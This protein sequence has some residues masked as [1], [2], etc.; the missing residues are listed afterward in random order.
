[1]SGSAPRPGKAGRPGKAARPGQP[2]PAGQPGRYL[3]P[4]HPP[5]THVPIAAYILAAGFDVISVAGGASRPW[6]GQ[7]WHAGTFV[8]VGG[9][10]SCLLT[11][12]S[13][14]ADLVRFGQHRPGAV[15][16]LG[17]HVC[18]MAAVFMVGVLDVALRLAA[19]H[20]ASTPPGILALTLTAAA[21]VGIGGYLGGT[22]VYRYGTGVAA[23][24]TAVASPAA[25]SARTT[26]HR[27]RRSW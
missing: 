23:T 12:I 7:L 24:R 15:R 4:L 10:V 21:G 3:R 9:L 13:G 19:Y 25:D 1:M 20:K 5:F 26:R 22:L 11:M 8:L 17:A 14:F 18:V 2:G 27:A 6:A 16:T